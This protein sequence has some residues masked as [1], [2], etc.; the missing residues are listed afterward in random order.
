MKKITLLSIL[1]AFVTALSFTACNSSDSDSTET[2]S[3]EN[4]QTMISNLGYMQNGNLIY[5]SEN[6]L[7]VNDVTDTIPATAYM[8]SGTTKATD[9][10]IQS[11]YG[12]ASFQFPVST[13][14]NFISDKKLAEKIGEM[15]SQTL[16]VY[17]IP[18]SITNQSYIANPDDIKLGDITTDSQT[19][20]D[21]TIKFYSNYYLGGF[22]TNQTSKNTYFQIY[23]VAGAIYVN[24]SQT[25]LLQTCTINSNSY[26]PAYLFTTNK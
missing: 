1:A 18:Y 5:Y 10:T 9:G 17:L 16:K 22:A 11:Y 15:E 7:N 19:Y 20:K 2:I 26:P 25:S 12:I 21:V 14:K 3:L 4:Q 23:L 8:T 24:G 6:K 13:L